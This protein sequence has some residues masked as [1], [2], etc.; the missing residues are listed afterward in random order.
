MRGQDPDRNCL[1]NDLE[2]AVGT[3]YKNTFGEWHCLIVGAGVFTQ[4]YQPPAAG[5]RQCRGGVVT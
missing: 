2:P 3:C 1:R 5:G 4:A